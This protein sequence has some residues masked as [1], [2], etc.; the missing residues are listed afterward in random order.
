MSTPLNEQQL[1][2][3][4]AALNPQRISK[5]KQGGRDLSYLEAW[6]VKATLIRVFGFGG[7]SSEV[8]EAKIIN[9]RSEPFQDSK[10]A[11]KY[12]DTV[13]V[14]VTVRLTIH[15]LGA[16][17][18]ETAASSQTGSQGFGDV[19]DFAF[20]TAESD[21]L[22]RA[23]IFLGTQFG[24]S[25][26]NNGSFNE[27]I[28][29]VVAPGQEFWNGVRK[30]PENPQEVREGVAVNDVRAAGPEESYT[31]PQFSEQQEQPQ[32]QRGAAP[33]SGAQLTPE[34]KANNQQLMNK[35]NQQV[36]QKEA[37]GNG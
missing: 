4:M 28:R 35:L 23:A 9:E 29:T 11:T 16:V 25:L 5:R 18:T 20:K 14:M 34:Q 26:Y 36:A 1:A 8:L 22:K 21:A 7:F 32:Q 17:Y 33:L 37:G 31:H 24:L 6:D 3:L 13:S 27:V 15:Q 10:G 2:I 30:L 19:A 12:K